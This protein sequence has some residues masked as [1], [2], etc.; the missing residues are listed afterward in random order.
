MNQIGG[1]NDSSTT[2]S[3]F[4]FLDGT[5]HI[6]SIGELPK[7]IQ[8]WIEDNCSETISLWDEEGNLVFVSR[9][10]H[11]ILGYFPKEIIGRHW[12]TIVS[13]DD[14]S[15]MKLAFHKINCEAETKPTVKINL[16]DHNEKYV[17]CECKLDKLAD[18]ENHQ[19]YYI[20]L[21]QDIT[22]KKELE[23]MMVSYEKMSI[24][25][26]LAAGVA[27]EIRNPLTSLKGFL[28][29][30]QAGGAQKEAYYN[31]MIDEIKKMEQITSEL[32][33][34]SK[35]L[36]DFRQMEP[37]GTMV[38]DIIKLLT[39]QAKIKGIDFILNTAGDVLL[40]CDRSQIKQVLI[41][42]VKNAIEAMENEGTITIDI[43]KSQSCVH[44]KIIDEGPGIDDAIIHKLG[45]PFFTTKEN[46]T[47]LGLMVTK[48]ILERHHADLQIYNNQTKGSTFDIT[49]YN[50]KS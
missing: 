27:H 12:S 21:I 49:F 48:Q 14:Y 34:I 19:V 45:E 33:Y 30:L 17:W 32:L 15:E 10:I 5:A 35:P 24:A 42:I 6:S 18:L 29:L 25:G 39:P 47:G 26:Q 9:S 11:K 50:T 8:D 3:D 28:Q 16:L 38:A 31:I 41:N 43:S 36:T 23:N 20:V 2:G 37:L 7:L 40:Y 4:K 46:G 44:L 1:E 22:D 13:P